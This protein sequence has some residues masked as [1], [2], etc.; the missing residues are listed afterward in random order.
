MKVEQINYLIC[1]YLRKKMAESTYLFNK[2]YRQAYDCKKQQTRGMDLIL[3]I[4][5]K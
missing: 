1:K 3:F 2:C 5:N 4:L